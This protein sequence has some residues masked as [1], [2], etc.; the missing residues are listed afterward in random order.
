MKAEY[1][2]LCVLALSTY[3]D[4]KNA[5]KYQA[6]ETTNLVLHTIMVLYAFS[7]MCSQQPMH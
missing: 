5:K 7:L 6:V 2:S 1:M 4:G 3:P